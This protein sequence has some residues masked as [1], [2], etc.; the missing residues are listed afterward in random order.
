MSNIIIK[1]RDG[2]ERKFIHQER[3]GGSYTKR[4]MLVNGFAIVED[5]WERKSIFPAD[6]ILEIIER[7]SQ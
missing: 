6:L 5:E 7:D 4:L 1:F 2:T 3:S